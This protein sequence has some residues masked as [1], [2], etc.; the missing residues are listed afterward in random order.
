VILHGGRVGARTTSA[1]LPDR[2]AADRVHV[3][4]PNTAL[5]LANSSDVMKIPLVGHGSATPDA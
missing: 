4:T 5:A 3:G 1:Y 2:E